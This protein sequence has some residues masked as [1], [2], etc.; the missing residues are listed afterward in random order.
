MNC[1]CQNCWGVGSPWTV[2]ALRNYVR[3]QNPYLVFLMETKANVKRMEKVKYKLGFSNGLFVPNRGR[4]GGLP[5]LWSKEVSLE[6]Q[7]Y[8]PHHIDAIISEQQNN[9]TWRFIGFYGHPETHLRKESQNLLSYLSNQF[10]LPQFCCGDFNE[11]LSLTE[12]SGGAL[13]SQH[14]MD[15]FREAVNLCGFQDLGFFGP[16]FTWCNLQEGSNRVYLRL[17]RAFANSNWLN[18][19]GDVRVH[20]QIES[21]SD[22]CFL[23]IS[24]SSFSPPSRK[25]RFHFEALWA[26]RED[27]HEII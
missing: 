21:T 12:K 18:L 22:H 3:Q 11:I 19:F 7:S 23:K 26:K 2:F 9:N 25:R 17:D 10:F 24:D 6:I 20:H 4:S 16:K 15:G 14:Q 8:S 13:R 27:C 5:L 1:L